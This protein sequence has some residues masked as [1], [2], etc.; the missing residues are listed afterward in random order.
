MQRFVHV[1]RLEHARR[2][3]ADGFFT[4]ELHGQ[5]LGELHELV[6]IGERPDQ[7]TN[8]AREVVLPLAELGVELRD[9][10][11]VDELFRVGNE[12]TIGLH[13]DRHPKL[14]AH[15]NAWAQDRFGWHRFHAPRPSEIA[16][17]TAFGVGLGIVALAGVTWYLR[18][19]R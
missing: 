10:K 12:V 1:S 16:G 13:R 3:L 17:G 15:G 8:D 19:A 14:A 2:E 6:R 4:R 11:R 9:P 5:G 7:L 18:K